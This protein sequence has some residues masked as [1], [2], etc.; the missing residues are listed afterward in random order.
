M[1]HWCNCSQ[2]CTCSFQS[3]YTERFKITWDK[4][5]EANLVSSNLSNTNSTDVSLPIKP[6]ENSSEHLALNISEDSFKEIQDAIVADENISE[7]LENENRVTVEIKKGDTLSSI[8]KELDI[9]SEITRVLNLG[10]DAKPLKRIYPGQKIHFTFGDSGLDKIE[11]EKSITKSLFFY[12]N[13]DSYLI[14]EANRELEKISQVATGSI[15]NSLFLAGQNAGMS[16][17]LIM[18]LAG[19]FGW[20]IDFALD[21]RQGDYFTVIYDELFLDG[22]KVGDGNITAAEFLITVKVIVLIVIRIAITKLNIIL[23]MAKACVNH[24]YAHQ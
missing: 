18:D 20:D 2:R 21:I 3:V 24:F 13:E 19:I 17:G 8:F 4:L 15:N 22:E 7:P 10:K 5:P 1:F 11:L 14:E 23:L 16:D 9:H 12:R 6:V